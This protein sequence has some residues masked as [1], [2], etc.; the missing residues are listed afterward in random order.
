MSYSV[1]PVVD[2]DRYWSPRFAEAD[3][4]E[5][6]LADATHDLFELLMTTPDAPW[7]HPPS[8][9]ADG[10]TALDVFTESLD[11]GQDFTGRVLRVLSAA[12]RQEPVGP[13]AVRLLRDIARNQA[14]FA[15]DRIDFMES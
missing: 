14:R 9:V 6:A 1:N 2:A 5:S 4:Y 15:V 7:V 13:D 12:A 8:S 10:T 11:S 3:R